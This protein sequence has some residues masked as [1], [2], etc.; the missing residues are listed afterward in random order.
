MGCTCSTTNIY[1]LQQNDDKVTYNKDGNFEF[2]SGDTRSF[3]RHLRYNRRPRIFW[4]YVNMKKMNKIKCNSPISFI[5]DKPNSGGYSQ[6]SE[7]VSGLIF[8]HLLKNGK[9]G[10]SNVITIEQEYYVEALDVLL[11]GENKTPKVEDEFVKVVFY[12]DLSWEREVFFTISPEQIEE[13]IRLNDEIQ[14]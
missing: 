10:V 1:V 11:S 7:Y 5:R 2:T 8:E 6:N 14:R 4:N 12:D 13:L 3:L 9:I